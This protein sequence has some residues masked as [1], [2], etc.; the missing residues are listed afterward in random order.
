MKKDRG[1]QSQTIQTVQNAAV[2][3]QEAPCVF[4]AEV[5][6][7]G[8][9]CDVANK[10]EDTYDQANNKGKGQSKRRKIQ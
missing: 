5:A 7:N 9:K 1:N 4:G 8:G 2:A 6:L 10:S 3:G